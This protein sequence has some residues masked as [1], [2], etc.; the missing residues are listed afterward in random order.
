MIWCSA[1]VSISE[2]FPENGQVLP[3]HIAID[4]ILMSF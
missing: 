3:K 4:V 1:T 2:Q